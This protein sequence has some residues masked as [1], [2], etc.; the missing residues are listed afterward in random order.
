MQVNDAYTPQTPI[1]GVMHAFTR[2]GRRLKAKQP[3]DQLD[4]SAHVVLFALRCN[5]ALRLSDLAGKLELDASTASRHVRSLEQLGLIRRSPDPDDGRAFRVEL[6]EQ[7]IEQ[8]EASARHR[9]E[10]L[11]AAMEGWSEEDVQTFER[12]MTRF[13]DGVAARTEAPSSSAWADKGWAAVAPRL[14][15]AAAQRRTEPDSATGSDPA[16][17]EN[18]DDN[19]ESTR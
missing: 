12:L 7:G 17:R 3:G 19:L 6:T 5:G 4:H 1:E 14:Q 15:S 11:S 10:L 2:I 9:M 16:A 8:W 18:N 13:A